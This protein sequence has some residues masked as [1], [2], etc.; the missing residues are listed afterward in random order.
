MGH[1]SGCG[2]TTSAEQLYQAYKKHADGK[3]GIVFADDIRHARSIAG[4][5]RRH[6]VRS[7]V[8]G[9]GD[10][11]EVQERK[12]DGFEAGMTQVLVCTD[13][14]SDGMRCPDVDFVQLANNTGSL[15]TYLHQ[16][17]CAMHPGRD[18]EYGEDGSTVQPRRLTVLDHAGLSTRFGLPTDGRDWTRLFAEGCGKKDGRKAVT[19]KKTEKAAEPQPAA[20]TKWQLRMQR[21]LGT[22]PQEDMSVQRI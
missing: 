13:Y 22:T 10:K 8:I 15:N 9:F 14:F 2:S 17:G 7:E 4:C 21:L 20:H 1:A 11:A 5:Y 12:L 3:R 18:E 16:V 19:G 6:G